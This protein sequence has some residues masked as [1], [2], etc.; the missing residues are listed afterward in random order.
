MAKV[1]PL[2][3]LATPGNAQCIEK[4]CA[5]WCGTECV[6]IAREKAKHGL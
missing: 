4:R 2:K 1:C 5:W 6:L 3:F